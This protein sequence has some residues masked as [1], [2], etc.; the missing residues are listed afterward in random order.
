MLAGHAQNAS[1]K[2]QVSLLVQDAISLL[3]AFGAILGEGSPP[4][5]ALPRC[6]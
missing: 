5:M 2:E 4:N 3:A 1:S 6:S